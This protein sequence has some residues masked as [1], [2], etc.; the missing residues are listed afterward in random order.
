MSTKQELIKNCVDKLDALQNTLTPL[1]ERSNAILK[2]V[3]EECSFTKKVNKVIKQETID[4]INNLAKSVPENERASMTS[5]HFHRSVL[6]KSKSLDVNK[7]L[8]DIR[9]CFNGTASNHAA[10]LG[11]QNII[12]FAAYLVKLP[13]DK[14]DSYGNELRD[15][16]DQSLDST[17][18]A[19]NAIKETYTALKE[20]KAISDVECD[21]M[22]KL[23]DYVL[24][25]V[26]EHRKEDVPPEEQEAGYVK[27]SMVAQILETSFN[28]LYTI[29]ER[30]RASLANVK[31]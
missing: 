24:T 31:D 25:Q 3:Q 22:V 12:Y 27:L 18:A 10:I 17:E 28:N 16:F 2:Q 6:E 14:A 11:E 30:V 23:A 20:E 26:E 4:M 7:F 15:I 21:L 19:G 8:S 13:F 5:T 1:H 9:S 29:I